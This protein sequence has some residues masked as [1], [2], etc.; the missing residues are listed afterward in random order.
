MKK[1][2]IN[3]RLLSNEAAEVVLKLFPAGGTF[4]EEAVYRTLRKIT[5]EMIPEGCSKTPTQ[6]RAEL[7]K[8]VS[9]ELTIKI[10][11]EGVTCEKCE[12]KVTVEDEHQKAMTKLAEMAVKEHEKTVEESAEGSVE[13]VSVEPEEAAT[14]E[15]KT[16]SVDDTTVEGTKEPEIVET[17]MVVVEEVK[18]AVKEDVKKQQVAKASRSSKKKTTK[19]K[20]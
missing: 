11:I 3:R 6:I 9:E 2:Y 17:E 16:E 10:D 8:F 13:D 4:S 19:K 15:I 18:P 1:V 5:K 20:K 14:E 7:D 12:R